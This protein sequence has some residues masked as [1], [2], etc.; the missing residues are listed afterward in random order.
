MQSDKGIP[1]LGKD[2]R[3]A[4]A[5]NSCSGAWVLSSILQISSV[6]IDQTKK[7]PQQ[8]SPRRLLLELVS[9]IIETAWL[10][11]FGREAFLPESEK[12]ETEFSFFVGCCNVKLRDDVF[13]VDSTFIFHLVPALGG[14]NTCASQESARREE[15]GGIPQS[16]LPKS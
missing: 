4:S 14:L 9:Q 3:A 7:C 10:Y 12:V 8:D 13:I 1:V 15:R 5:S 11:A 2:R 6:E 16:L